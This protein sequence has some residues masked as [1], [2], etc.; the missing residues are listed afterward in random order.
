VVGSERLDR[1]AALATHAAELF[2]DQNTA[3]RWMIAP[4]RALNGLTPLALCETDIGAR[5]A[6]R[7]LSALQHGAVV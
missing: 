7:V 6:R 1:V 4:N 2:E 3:R 5:Q